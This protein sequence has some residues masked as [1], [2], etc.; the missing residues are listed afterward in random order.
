MKIAPARTAERRSS[1]LTAGELESFRALLTA[2]LAVESEQAAAHDAVA[3]QL[4]GHLDTD[5]TIERELALACAARAR[6]AIH[7]IQDALRRLRLGTYG[8][9]EACGAPIPVERLEVIPHARW[10][11]VCQGREGR[12]S[13]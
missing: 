6:E 8:T 9:C 10:C 1:H 11:V 12:R 3:R 5:S 4:T 7:D 2:Q 13:R